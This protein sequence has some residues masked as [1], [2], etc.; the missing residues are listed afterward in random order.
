LVELSELPGIQAV[1]RWLRTERILVLNVAGPREESCPG[2]Y[3]RAYE[4]MRELLEC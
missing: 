2:I 4:F 1:R 3:A